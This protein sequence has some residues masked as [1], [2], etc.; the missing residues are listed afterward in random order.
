MNLNSILKTFNKTLVK[1]NAFIAANDKEI[2]ANFRT[3][4]RLEEDNLRLATEVEKATHVSR[5]LRKLIGE[6]K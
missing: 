5:N 3:M 4:T 6:D 1:L 2:T